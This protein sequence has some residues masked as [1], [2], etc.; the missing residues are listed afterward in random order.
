MAEGTIAALIAYRHQRTAVTAGVDPSRLP[1]FE[2]PGTDLLEARI[3][4]G[5]FV[6]LWEAL[7]RSV[8]DPALPIRVI[9]CVTTNDYDVIGFSCM[10]RATLGEGLSQAVRFARIWSDSSRWDLRIDERTATLELQIA[11]PQRLGVR[12]GSESALAEMIHGGRLLTGLRYA[13]VAVRFRHPRPPDASAHERFFS[14]PIEWS[15]PRTEVA[16][17]A[18]LLAQP[19]L[20]ADPGLA[21]YFERHAAALL[22]K[23]AEP[24]GMEYRLR[25]AL[26]AE[27]PRGVPTLETIAPRLGM[28]TRTLRRRLQEAETTFREVLDQTRCE[29]AKRYLAD[30]QLPVGAVGFMVGFSEPSAFHRAFKRWTGVTPA[31]FRASASQSAA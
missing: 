1:P 30:P 13:P 20:K 16:I 8:R 28:S 10:T 6:D 25:S 12:C 14:A 2:V 3:P 21:A 23:C 15:A 17:D 5:R 22:E 29:L 11:E 7:I 27:L 31:A 18:K 19:L 9:E 26:A 4:H 24:E